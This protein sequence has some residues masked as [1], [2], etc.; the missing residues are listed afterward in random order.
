M[1]SFSFL[2]QTSIKFIIAGVNDGQCVPSGLDKSKTVCEIEGWCP[3]ENDEL[4]LKNNYPIFEEIQNFTVLIKNTIRFPLFNIL[5]RNIDETEE[6]RTELQKCLFDPETHPRCP[7]FKIADIL[8]YANT[9]FYEIAR[10]G[11]KNKS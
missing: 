11:G 10:Y 1:K 6:M 2:L 5:R 4:P 7:I 8:K 3:T 9:D